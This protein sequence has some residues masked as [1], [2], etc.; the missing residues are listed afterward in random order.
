MDARRVILLMNPLDKPEQ[1][2]RLAKLLFEDGQVPQARHECILAL[3]NAPRY[4]EALA[5]L[6]DIAAKMDAAATSSAPAPEPKP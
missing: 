1:H 3:E 6:L 2:Y 4:R 5:L